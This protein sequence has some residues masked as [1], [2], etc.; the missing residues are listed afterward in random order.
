MGSSG[1]ADDRSMEVIGRRHPEGGGDRESLRVHFA[2]GRGGRLDRPPGRQLAGDL[3]YDVHRP[4]TGE[5][6][7]IYA[8]TYVSSA[9]QAFGG[10]IASGLNAF[11]RPYSTLRSIFVGPFE[12]AGVA[13]DGN[14]S[15]HAR[16]IA[17]SQALGGFSGWIL[18]ASPAR[19]VPKAPARANP[20][21]IRQNV[22]AS[23]AVRA[24][25]DA[26]GGWARHLEQTRTSAHTSNV[27]SVLRGTNEKGQL[28]SRGSWRR[29]T[30]DQAWEGAEP[31]P[32]GGRL[33][34]T[35][36]TEVTVPP[37]SGQPRDWDIN[38]HP[39]WSK[40]EFK[41]DVT[42]QEVLDNYQEGTSLECPSCNR[43]AGN[44]R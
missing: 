44:R 2:S 42:R 40:R 22:A 41:P 37:R 14:L 21:W 31:G 33:C 17:G 8:G 11:Y 32:T 19:M 6:G 13:L 26:K 1:L 27:S 7:A 16:I 38:H 29:A 25:V 4:I 12:D 24:A 9:G 34:P 28:T 43:S 15:T 36:S 35:C 39:A 20:A 10:F 3:A 23:Q 18:A 30:V 5:I